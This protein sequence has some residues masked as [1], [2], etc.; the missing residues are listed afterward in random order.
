MKNATLV[1]LFI[2]IVILSINYYIKNKD[3]VNIKSTID[4]RY[5]KVGDNPDKLQA[6]N[7]LAK[8][9]NNVSKLLDSLKNN[10]EPHFIRLCE[11]YNPNSLRENTNTAS[12]KAYSLNKGEEISLCLRNVDNTLITDINTIMFVLIHELAHIM[13][14]EIGHP[15]IFWENMNLLL[16]K[17][18]EIGIYT[19]IDYS[20]NPVN[21]CGMNVNKTPYRF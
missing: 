13:T 5:Y 20:K 15:D 9:N 4:G 3:I 10:K 11:K 1:L 14:K 18:E 21:Y 19:P 6:A 8:I 7:L 16:K 2:I 17:S 12:Y